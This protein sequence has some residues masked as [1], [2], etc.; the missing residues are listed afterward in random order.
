MYAATLLAAA[1]YF[2]KG[3]TF[4]RV[5]GSCEALRGWVNIIVRCNCTNLCII[6][7]VLHRKQDVKSDIYIVVDT[8]IVND[9]VFFLISERSCTVIAENIST[10]LSAW[11]KHA[12]NKFA[13]WPHMNIR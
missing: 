7:V 5:T 2:F 8:Y 9:S 13:R 10:T 6:S 1:V 4:K 12:T 3:L 11:I